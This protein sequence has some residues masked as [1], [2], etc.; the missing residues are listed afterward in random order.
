M[1][2]KHDSDG[3][4]ILKDNRCV[5]LKKQVGKR[6]YFEINLSPDKLPLLLDVNNYDQTLH[7]HTGKCN[8]VSPDSGHCNSTKHSINCYSEENDDAKVQRDFRHVLKEKAGNSINRTLNPTQLI[9]EVQRE[10]SD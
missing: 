7:F 4:C 9:Q 5:Y 1:R 6:K 10:I 2:F 3:S 8:G